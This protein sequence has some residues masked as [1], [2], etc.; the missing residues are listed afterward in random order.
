MSA[1][2]FP[3]VAGCKAPDYF[4]FSLYSGAV[5]PNLRTADGNAN[6]WCGRRRQTQCEK[7]GGSLL[8]VR[9]PQNAA[10]GSVQWEAVSRR[11]GIRHGGDVIRV[12]TRSVKWFLSLHRIKQ[13]GMIAECAAVWLMDEDVAG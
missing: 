11:L 9:L 10:D 5:G 2:T 12:S 6:T 3:S 8:R 7:G 13:S 1:R 4:L